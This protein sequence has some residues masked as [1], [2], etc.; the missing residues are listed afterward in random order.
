MSKREMK[1]TPLGWDHP[2]SI[3]FHFDLAKFVLKMNELIKEAGGFHY[4]WA[5]HY[6]YTPYMWRRF[7]KGMVYPGTSRLLRMCYDFNLN[8]YDF[9][10]WSRPKHEKTY[11]RESFIPEKRA[12]VRFVKAYTERVKE[13]D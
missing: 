11:H 10:I 3:S 1:V 8:P 5:S 9:F 7:R 13:N 12:K 6:G 2:K 4:E